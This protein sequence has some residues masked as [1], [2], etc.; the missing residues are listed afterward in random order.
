MIKGNKINLIPATLDDRQK[1]YEWCFQSETTKSHTG[2]PDYPEKSIATYAEF[3]DD[4]YEEYYFTGSRSKDGRGFIIVNG[5]KPI[6]FIS[7]SSFH[8]KPSTAEFDIWMNCEANCG[9]GFGV[10]AIVTLGDYLNKSIGICKLIIAPSI[11][12]TRAIKSYKKAG[13]TKSDNVMNDFLLE[14]YI[15]LYGC[16]DYG[17]DETALLVKRFDVQ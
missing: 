9:K 3:C 8:L 14:E 13:F 6:G 7:Y 17:T 4:Y 16:G 15:A 2:P 11:K 10:D 5:A 1:V 12:N